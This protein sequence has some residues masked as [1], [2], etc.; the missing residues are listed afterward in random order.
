MKAGSRGSS[1]AWPGLG[2]LALVVFLYA[3]E[4]VP[5]RGFWYRDIGGFWSALADGFVG[6]VSSGTLPLWNPNFSFGMPMLADPGSQS[7]YPFTWLNLLLPLTTYYKVYAL[8]HAFVGALGL[9][10]LARRQSLGRPASFVAAA[11]WLDAGPFQEL[12]SQTHHF[13]GAAFMPWVL[14]ALDQALARPTT[15]SGVILGALAAGQVL[16]GS[17]DMCLMTVF[18]AAAWGAVKAWRRPAAELLQVARSVLGVALP[19]A[20]LLSA[21]QWLPTLDLL[22][23]GARAGMATQA[24]TYW[25]LHPASLLDLF[26]PRAV[27]A[28]PLREALREALYESREPLYACLYLGAP[29]LILV[30]FGLIAE[31]SQRARFCLAGFGLALVAALGRHTPVYP[32]LVRFTPLAMLR[33]PTKYTIAA[34][35]F[36]ALLVGFAAEAWLSSETGPARRRAATALAVALVLAAAGAAFTLWLAPSLLYPWLSDETLARA[37]A[38]DELAAKLAVAVTLSALTGWCLA[39]LP[40]GS[41]LMGL[42]LAIVVADLARVAQGVNV[43]GP[44]ELLEY[45]PPAAA[46]LP[47]RARLYVS[48][49]QPRHWLPQQVVRVPAGW[50][51]AWAVALGRG[52]MLWPPLGGRFGFRGSFDGDF[53]GLAAPLVSN[54]TLILLQAEGTPLASRLLRTAGV[55]YVVTVDDKPWPDLELAAE[56]PSVFRLPIRLLRVPGTR[57]EALLVGGSRVAAEP[58]SFQALGSVDFDPATETILASG[59]ALAPSERPFEGRL[60]VIER[61]ADR[62]RAGTR[63]NAPALLV[64]LQSYHPGWRAFLDGAPAPIVRA[65]I[66]FQAVAV[67]AGEHVVE[68]RYRPWS[69]PVGLGLSFAGVALVAGLRLRGRREAPRG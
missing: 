61:G 56:L 51:R 16:A 38:V 10:R 67:P 5:G 50:G 57:P 53:T 43:P 20:L 23:W 1:R 45:R 9:Y 29:A 17:G 8:S 4:L 22:R 64:F 31:G 46:M 3:P 21:A 32:W 24:N 37:V 12:L 28:L 15:R 11:V 7:L 6:V 49:A 59:P 55:D 14:L 19:L 47:A 52:E 26:I 65:D 25:S 30:G 33:Y 41:R 40:P 42:P 35:F 34:A 68:F 58:E 69:V 27:S 62:L 2:L 18:V 48:Q 66:L 44:R 54:L 63:S 13:A 39:R 36:W 60:R